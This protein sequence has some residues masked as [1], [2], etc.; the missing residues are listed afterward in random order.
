MSEKSKPVRHTTGSSV[1]QP[2]R[3][4]VD[5][6]FTDRGRLDSAVSALQGHGFPLRTMSVVLEHRANRKSGFSAVDERQIRTL[7]TSLAGAVA[8]LAA[9][10]VTIMSGGAAGLALAASAV[11]G[12]SAATG[13]HVFK[14][15]QGFD[16]SGSEDRPDEDVILS[17]SVKNAEDETRA[18]QILQ[19]HGAV[20]IW[21]QDRQI[22]ASEAARP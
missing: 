11:A 21:A 9:A 14:T 2:A 13:V 6:V 16:G 20:Q 5:S 17:V 3:R 15:S 22:R 10:G 8:A 4:E 18:V 12:A 1:R 19:E 7:G